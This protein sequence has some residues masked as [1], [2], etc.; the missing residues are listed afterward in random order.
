MCLE[1]LGAT[2]NVVCKAAAIE[3]RAA[4]AHYTRT[5]ASTATKDNHDRHLHKCNVHMCARLSL[6]ED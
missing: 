3:V 6:C 4:R 2:C 5:P 1:R